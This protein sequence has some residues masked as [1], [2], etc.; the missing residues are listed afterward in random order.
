LEGTLRRRELLKGA[1]AITASAAAGAGITFFSPGEAR[2]FGEAPKG[3]EG[4]TVPAELRAESVLEIFLYGGVSQYESF[5]C[6]PDHGAGDGTHWHAFLASGEVQAACD[7]CSLAGPLTQP[8]APD[9]E[10][11]TVHLGPFV[12]P[13][14]A[15]ADVLERT[16]ISITS[17]DLEP[18]EAA[19]PLALAGRRPGHP[20]LAGLGA[21]VQRYF[22]DR[23]GATGRAPFSY[24]LLPSAQ[25]SIPTDNVR[26][27]I[28]IGAHPGAARPLS[29]RADASSELTT[30]LAREVVGADRQ[31]HDALVQGYIKQYKERLRWRGEGDP[32][33]SPRFVDLAAGAAAVANAEAISSVLSPSLLQSVS[34]VHCAAT[35]ETDA[36]GMSMRLA[37]H[38]L[39]HPTSPAKYVCVIDGGFLPAD[40]GGGYDTHFENSYSQ[41]RNLSYTLKCLMDLINAPGESDPAK[42][43]LDKTMIVLTTEFGRSPY[44][45]GS[46]GRNHWPYGYPTVLIGGPVRAASRGVFGA[47]GPDAR[48]TLASTPLESR[49][50]ALLALGIWP[51]APES[52]SV[53]DVVGAASEAEAAI[54][55]KKR[56]LGIV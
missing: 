2:A 10:G 56:L 45:Q 51:F 30:L 16:R 6:I 42:L 50:A 52:Y 5:Y 49:V 14:R 54:L 9:A 36:V 53:P 41:A 31:A 37:A 3:A 47:C 13:L 1:A 21:H 34:G 17:H 24:V 28:A 29:L 8:F 46:F 32:L 20:A 15:R 55:V 7:E 11:K 23:E 43:N 39:T 26:S 22:I 33:R 27:A 44:K 19:I 48:A 4:A 38:L 40:G 35:A 25:A 18:H 12:M